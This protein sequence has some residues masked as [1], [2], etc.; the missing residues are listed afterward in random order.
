MATSKRVQSPQSQYFEKF[1]YTNEYLDEM[2]PIGSSR[3]MCPACGLFFRS[4]TGFDKHRIDDPKGKDGRR[5]LNT[6]EMLEKGMVQ[7]DSGHWV[8]EKM[9]SVPWRPGI[10]SDS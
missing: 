3:C 8:T 4:S 9:D 7:T 10:E 6:T 5:C 1:G 2:I